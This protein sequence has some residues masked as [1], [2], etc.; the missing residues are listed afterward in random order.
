VVLAQGI[1]QA[2]GRPHAERV[3]LEMAGER[4]RGA[5]LYVSLEPCSHH[6]RTPPCIDAVRE[7]GIARVVTALEDPDTRVSGRGH[8]ILREAGVRVLCGVLAG[9]ASRAHRGHILRVTQGRPA[10]MLKIARTADGYAARR[11]G[12][13][14]MISGP[15]PTPAPT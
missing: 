8:A 9:E 7:A 5:T 6:G 3:A 12:G 2:G 1:T 11:D 10:V 4:A 15:A 13:R 14:L